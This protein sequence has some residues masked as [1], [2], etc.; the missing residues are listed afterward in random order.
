[1]TIWRI[2]WRSAG[3]IGISAGFDNHMED[4]GGVLSTGDYFEIG[5]MAA[6]AAR[7]NNGGCFAVLEGGA[8][9]TMCWAKTSWP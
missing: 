4:W 9:T 8:T 1:M 6:G 2:P 7:R 5:K 3:I